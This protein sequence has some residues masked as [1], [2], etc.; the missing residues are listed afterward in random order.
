VAHVLPV[1]AGIPWL[2]F[3]ACPTHRRIKARKVRFASR[4]LHRR[5]SDYL[6]RTISF[7]ELDASVQRWINH[8]R[9]ADPWGLRRHVLDGLRFAR[10][11]NDTR[12]LRGVPVDSKRE[13]Q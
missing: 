13:K 8:V 2:G 9:Y 1:A 7:A 4:T 11:P 5:L 3:V 6:D 10:V 12:R